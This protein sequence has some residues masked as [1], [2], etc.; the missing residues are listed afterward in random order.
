MQNKSFLI[1]L[2]SS[3]IKTPRLRTQADVSECKLIIPLLGLIVSLRVHF[4]D[5]F[6][7]IF[8]IVC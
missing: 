6:L 8:S 4:F 5:I 7:D 1:I 2:I 3:N